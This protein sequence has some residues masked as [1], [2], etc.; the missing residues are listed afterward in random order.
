MTDKRIKE[1]AAKVAAKLRKVADEL[2]NNLPEKKGKRSAAWIY[3]RGSAISDAL[4][5]LDAIVAQFDPGC[6]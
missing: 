3:K 1:K 6:E 2:T 4:R 5:E